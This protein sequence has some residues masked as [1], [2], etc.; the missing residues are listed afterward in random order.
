[1]AN[2]ITDRTSYPYE[3][4]VYVS[5]T[6]IDKRTGATATV[7]D[8]D[9]GRLVTGG[10]ASGVV[11]GRNDVLTAAHVVQT[12]WWLDQTRYGI[13]IQVYPG[14]DNSP[15][16]APFGSYT[17]VSWSNYDV[18]V[19]SGLISTSQS[20][21]DFALLNFAEP[22]GDK[23]GWMR[24]DSSA[25]NGGTANETGY[26]GSGPGLMNASVTYY[27]DW[28]YYV[29]HTSEPLGPGASGGPLW[30][31]N[32]DGTFVL[33]VLS[34]GNSS[35]DSYASLA[36]PGV[37]D[38]LNQQM[39]ANDSLIVATIGNTITLT[40]PLA[41][42]TAATA[43]WASAKTTSLADTIWTAAAYLPA[44]GIDA[45]PGVDVLN[46]SDGGL[47]NLRNI[48]SVEVLDLRGTLGANTVINMGTDFGTVY[49]G[50]G[51]DT[52]TITAA[53]ATVEGGAGNDTITV[54]AGNMTIDGGDGIDT[55]VLP[56]A[57]SKYQVTIGSSTPPAN[58]SGNNYA[59]TSIERVQFADRKV[60][61]DLNGAAGDTVKLIGAAFG[62]QYVTNAGFVGAGLSVFDAGMTTPQVAELVL[63][64]S[65]FRQLAGSRSNTDV[66][67]QLYRSVV[68]VAPPAADLDTFVGL[69]ENGMTQ[70]DL[71]V[72][73]ANTDLNAQ[74]INL[75][76][77]ASTGVEY[78]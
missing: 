68:G 33:G 52:I 3:T 76:G 4:I 47:I 41:F 65:A 1:M 22:F 2:E 31:S 74:H 72:R 8:A 48:S 34:S 7:F 58:G 39:A 30:Y 44:V 25:R 55:V 10:H 40:A 67:T 57:R 6:Y 14:A 23:L 60:A 43:V 38:W 64:S 45:G 61:L 75:V 35:T 29:Y 62:P 63:G 15:F 78:A 70:A 12:P 59:F 46:V 24:L 5:I 77:L 49:L 73:A 53:A 28:R 54:G 11:V 26:P 66:V 17:P 37:I 50:P 19:K 32:A 13:Q 27:S 16:S 9:A 36:A 69:L 71:L 51:G 56:L 20:Q 42:A 21:Y 18:V